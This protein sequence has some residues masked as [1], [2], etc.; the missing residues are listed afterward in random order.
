VLGSTSKHGREGF[1]NE[2]SVARSPT[3]TVK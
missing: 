1:L 3:S 2:G